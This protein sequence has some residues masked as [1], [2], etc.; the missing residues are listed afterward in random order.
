[1]TFEKKQFENNIEEQAGEWV[2]D[3]RFKIQHYQSNWPSYPKGPDSVSSGEKV[4]FMS[5][6]IKKEIVNPLKKEILSRKFKSLSEI[7][8]FIVK[9]IKPRVTE[10]KFGEMAN[11]QPE[12]RLEIGRG[13]KFYVYQFQ[14]FNPNADDKSINDPWFSIRI[15]K[16]D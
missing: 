8:E 14:W 3:S 9:F 10:E 15:T 7:K 4:V 16:V 12:V 1:M 5:N 2:V 11:V 13:N 6:I